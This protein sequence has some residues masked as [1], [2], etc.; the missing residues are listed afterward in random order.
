M[1][2][3][4]KSFPD[5]TGS[6]VDPKSRLDTLA[7]L[8]GVSAFPYGSG[9]PATP[10]AWDPTKADYATYDCVWGPDGSYY[11]CLADN[12][13]AG[14]PLSHTDW[15]Q[16]DT[17]YSWISYMN[18]VR[19]A[20]KSA[21][22]TAAAALGGVGGSA[23]AGLELI[24]SAVLSGPWEISSSYFVDNGLLLTCGL[25][26]NDSE[27][28][29][30]GVA[31]YAMKDLELLSQGSTCRLNI[32]GQIPGG[33]ILAGFTDNH[34]EYRFEASFNE[35]GYVKGY[36]TVDCAYLARVEDPVVTITGGGTF[37]PDTLQI[38]WVFGGSYSLTTHE[39]TLDSGDGDLLSGISISATIA[40]GDYSTWHFEGGFSNVKATWLGADAAAAANVISAVDVYRSTCHSPLPRVS[41]TWYGID[42]VTY[43]VTSGTYADGANCVAMYAVP[44]DYSPGDAPWRIRA[45]TFPAG[46]V[47]YATAPSSAPP[48]WFWQRTGYPC[49]RVDDA[50]SF[51]ATTRQ[52]Y[53]RE[54]DM[55]FGKRNLATVDQVKPVIDR[56]ATDTSRDVVTATVGYKRSGDSSMTRTFSAAAISVSAYQMEHANDLG[57]AAAIIVWDTLPLRWDGADVVVTAAGPVAVWTPNGTQSW[58]W[59]GDGSYSPVCVGYYEDSAVHYDDLVAVLA[60]L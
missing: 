51:T 29:S 46:S 1:A 58:S 35:E 11:Y 54:L 44:V 27:G 7:G 30:V 49:R 33:Q 4:L 16:Y 26:L 6:P 38:V 28:N 55:I 19:N 42:P 9:L 20:V 31:P 14:T 59:A 41:R 5:L 17:P 15:W 24:E 40:S 8:A 25:S 22:W 2:V 48:E 10:T 21:L 36:I 50:S 47:A 57:R 45:K 52:Q 56:S 39:V 3:R 12:P 34:N 37:D 13:P 53:V 32:V 18:T 60:L 23:T 43:E